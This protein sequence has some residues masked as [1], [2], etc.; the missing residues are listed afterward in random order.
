MEI[1]LDFGQKRVY[2]SVIVLEG[3]IRA[4][5]VPQCFMIACRA[6]HLYFSATLLHILS[7]LVGIQIRTSRETHKLVV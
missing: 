7:A 1:G 3:A 6:G 5:F 2:E 4:D